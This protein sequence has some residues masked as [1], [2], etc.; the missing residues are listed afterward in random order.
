MF[1]YRLRIPASAKKQL[2]G[3]KKKDRKSAYYILE[4]LN[5]D[6]FVGK[7]LGRDLAGRFS[8]RVGN[9]R[10]VYVIRRKDRI[11]EILWVKH[12]SVAYN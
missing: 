8:Y 11:V 7:V 2:N 3:L 5:D 10:V 9:F 6:P 4:E 12:R 1:E